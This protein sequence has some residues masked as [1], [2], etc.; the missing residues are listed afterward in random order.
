MR[1]HGKSVVAER[2]FPA[3]TN[4]SFKRRR[5]V[6]RGQIVDPRRPWRSS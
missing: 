1:D 6:I 3:M 4:V 2:I 5:N